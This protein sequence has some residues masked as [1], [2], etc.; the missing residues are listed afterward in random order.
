[1]NT[2]A[3]AGARFELLPTQ[4]NM[5]GRD[6][7]CKIVL[8]DPQCSR[9]HASVSLD[10]DGWWIR[11]NGSS[12]GTF[13]NGQTVN[14]ARLVDGTEIRVGNSV[15][16]FTEK[17]KA[18]TS[19][20]VTDRLSTDL[21]SETVGLTVIHDREMDP[22]ET[23]H[24][25]L[26]FLKG[27]NWGKD[28]FFLF[29]LSVKLLSVSDPELVVEVSMERLFDRTESAAAGFLWLSD[30]GNLTP[31]KVF[32]ADKAENVQ[33]DSELTQLSLIHI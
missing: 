6:W 18:Q 24:Y 20:V 13:V 9:M 30:D 26:D 32:P 11:D 28:F 14:E 7:E 22:Q 17:V 5:L 19:P 8:N 31:K 23:G 2:G 29:Q 1:M 33:L 3:S 25:T 27:H 21:G 16:S 12:N 15:F 4:E 10:E